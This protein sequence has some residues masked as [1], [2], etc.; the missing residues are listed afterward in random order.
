[1]TCI[2]KEKE[3]VKMH[4]EAVPQGTKE[5]IMQGVPE[6][7]KETLLRMPVEDAEIIIAR[8][9]ENESFRL[10]INYLSVCSVSEIDDFLKRMDRLYKQYKGAKQ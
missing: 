7:V 4:F 9:Q 10:I 2:T 5:E 6:R 1:M 3:T 8:Y